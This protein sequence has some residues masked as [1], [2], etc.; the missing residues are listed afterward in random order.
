LA[1]TEEARTPV[2][3]APA[4][5][6]LGPPAPPRR[7][8]GGIEAL[9]RRDFRFLFLSTLAT[10]YAQW[11]QMVGMGW[12]VYELTNRSAVQLAAVSATAGAVRLVLGPFTGVALDRWH[13]RSVVIW[14]TWLGA[15]Q[16]AALALLVL[17]GFAEV[18]HI[19]VFAMI[20][21]V[22]STL[23][24]NAR[25]AFV[26]DITDEATLA[27]AVTLNAIGQN[28]TRIT[29]P[30][31]AAALTSPFGNSGPFAFVAV[32][33]FIGTA[34]TLPISHVTRQAVGV[35]GN[36]LRAL[37]D[38]V[39]YVASDGALSGLMVLAI[40]PGLLV[41]PYVPLL[42]VFARE[43]LGMGA[44]AFGVL[45]SA[46]GIGSLIGLLALAFV[47]D[48]LRKGVLLTIALLV[49]TLF[50]VGFSQT[51]ELWLAVV[52]LAAAGLTHGLAMAWNQVL[53]QLLPRNEMRGRVTGVAQ[54]AFALMPL[55]A[56]PMGLV[57]DAWGPARGIGAFFTLA[58]LAFI[59]MLLL[60]KPLRC[61]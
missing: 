56:L 10:G 37:V 28:I 21:A 18:W 26:Y 51:S 14:S 8:R 15:L 46:I 30:S 19:Y 55:G 23:N 45:L 54:T 58:A 5:A 3:T 60:W 48:V 11:G 16:A 57:V 53:L 7:R 50:L 4:S 9:R 33:M 41:Y 61:V 31:I 27:N 17:A 6:P 43:A 25:A 34:C 32:M 22:I 13:R 29:G 40:I 36:P 49:Y 59:A 35:T 52:L 38:G 24:Q 1:R 20:D 42:P 47:G 39:R 2:L 44:G 12:L